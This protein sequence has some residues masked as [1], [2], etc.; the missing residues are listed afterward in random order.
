MDFGLVL[1]GGGVR[2]AYHVG[3]WEALAEMGINVSAVTGASIGAVNGA[4][5][6]A[7]AADKA[8]DMWLNIKPGDIV[9]LPEDMGDKKNL[10]SVKNLVPLM[11]EMLGSGGLD[12]APLEKILRGI[13]DED[14][15]LNSPIDFG[16][17]TYS[18]TERSIVHRF[19]RDIPKAELIPYIM[20]SACFPVFKPR[21]IDSKKFIDGGMADN[22]PVD[23]LLEK[24]LDDIITVDVQ[25]IGFYKTFNTAGRNIINIRCR[26]PETGTLDFDRAGIAASI[27][28][29]AFD[30]KKTFGYLAGNDYSFD[31]ASYQKA[32]GMYGAEILEGLEKAA[33]AFEIE[34]FKAYSVDELI[35]L[36]LDAYRAYEAE[37]AEETASFGIND[38][39]RLTDKKFLTALLVNE[40]EGGL[41]DFL[42]SKLDLIG[43]SFD[44]ACCI[45]YFKRKFG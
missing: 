12:T 32:R 28:E 23:L 4:I 27:A 42:K 21:V 20:A 34:R 3:V 18:V 9:K 1:A 38:I 41:P 11:H 44:A 15:L 39:P 26:Q 40:L 13:I 8:R 31:T 14:T 24:G 37:H 43:S 36:V 16:L 5:F 2:G 35:G 45:S 29:G 30:T 25:G 19:K 33:E 17:V 6:A 10:L 22:M 7:G